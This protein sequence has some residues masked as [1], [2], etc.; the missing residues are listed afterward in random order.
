MPF[1]ELLLFVHRFGYGIHELFRHVS[2]AID[3]GARADNRRDRP[4]DAR[5]SPCGD[6]ASLLVVEK[7]GSNR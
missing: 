2:P 4:V 5:F 6:E 3:H 1:E 7:A